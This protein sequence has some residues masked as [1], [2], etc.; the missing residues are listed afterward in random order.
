MADIV[1]SRVFIDGEKGITAAKLN[2]ITA[3]SVIQPAFYTSKPTAGT[4]DPTD[5]ALILKSGAY[6]QVPVSTLG[7]SAT[8]AQIWSTRLRSFN[9]VGN[10]N[11]EVCQRNVSNTLTNPANGAFIEDRWNIS[12]GNG[13]FGYSIAR[14]GAGTAV[15]GGV[16]LPGTNFVVSNAFMR[17]T[18]TAQQASLSGGEQLQLTQP[19]EGSNLRELIGDVHSVSLLVRSSVANLKFALSLRSPDATRSLVKLCTIPTANA[20]TLIQ[21]P[22][23]PVWDSGGNFSTVT[24][25]SGYILTVMLVS[26]PTFTAPAADTWQNG[27]FMG[28]PGMSN[29]AASPVNSTFDIAFVQ[30]EPGSACST[31]MD[32]PF[33]QNL[34]ECLRYFCKSYDYG[35]A[36]G[37]VD[38]NGSI[39]G[40]NGQA[41]LAGADFQ[42]P[43]RFPKTMARSAGTAPV[44][45]GQGLYTW[46]IAGTPNAVR[47]SAGAADRGISVFLGP[48][49][50]GFRG[51]TLS[52]G[53]IANSYG[54]FQYKM[55]TGW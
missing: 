27:N 15:G 16:V 12:K 9:S 10:P 5:I 48:G 46:T 28:A 2:D 47:D 41:A 34:D 26:G 24:G 51:M 50:G 32:K 42:C 37:A 38:G 52:A 53:L 45:S 21:L 44:I 13:T 18:L 3:S 1:T 33:T 23:L 17:I 35:V 30:H 25:V 19:I 6:A 4:A 20:W 14:T 55:D 29:F 39:T 22:N 11:F 43:I 31:L 7:G 8:Q 54:V 49:T 40:W 36:P